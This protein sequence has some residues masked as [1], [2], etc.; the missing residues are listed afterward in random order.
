VP[1]VLK[2]EKHH[3]QPSSKHIIIRVI[4]AI[5]ILCRGLLLMT[6]NCSKLSMTPDR[7]GLKTVLFTSG[8]RVSTSAGQPKGV[9]RYQEIIQGQTS[10]EVEVLLDAT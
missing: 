9:E 1:Q 3:R 6:P 10:I 5:T 4:A 8:L 2:K 7:G